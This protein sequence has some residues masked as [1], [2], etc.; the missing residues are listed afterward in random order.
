MP[1][2]RLAVVVAATA[3]V[4]AG[5]LGLSGVS[6]AATTASSPASSSATGGAASVQAGPGELALTVVLNPSDRATLRGLVERAPQLTD[7]QRQDALAAV[8]PSIATRARVAGVLR[9]AGFAITNTSSWQID[10][11]G[12]P[13]E[14][15]SFFGVDL[16][17][18][19]DDMHPAA[20]PV[21][22]SSIASSVTT[23]LGL[24]RRPVLSSRVLP[25]GG[26]SSA[27]LASAYGVA[28]T[29]GDGSG[30]TVATVQFSGWHRN[31][32]STYAS[33]A[34][35]AMPSV[36]EIPVGGASATSIDGN[37][38]VEVALDQEL[39]LAAAPKAAQRI[40]FATNDAQGMYSVWSQVAADVKP[41][42][43]TAVSTSWG[44]CESSTPSSVRSAVQDA[45]ARAVVAGG[46]VFAA[47]GDYGA[48]DCADSVHPERATPADVSFPASLPSVVGVGGTSLTKSGSGW[49]ETAWSDQS[50]YRGSG[51]GLSQT[52]PRP[53]YQNGI[54]ISGSTRAVPDISATADPTQG[55]TFYTQSAKS[56]TSSGFVL[57]G[58]TSAA[59]PIMAGQLAA[60]L[61]SFGCVSG[62]GD[63]HATLYGNPKDFRDV[64]SGNNLLYNAG[65]GYDLATG[66]GSPNWSALVN[67]LRPSCTR[68]ATRI[69]GSDRFTVAAMASQSFPTS[70]DTVFV[71]SGTNFPDAL[72]AGPA[73]AA[74]K[75]PLLLVTS[76]SVP[77]VTRAAIQRLAPERIVVV[78]GPVAVGDSVAAQLAG[79]GGATVT[80]IGGADRYAVS[81]AIAQQV[82]LDPTSPLYAGITPTG[83]YVASGRGYADA[84]SAGG[85]AA[86][87]G[88]PLLIVDGLAAG[89][90]DQTKALVTSMGGSTKVFGVGGPVVLAPQILN[91]LGG[92]SAVQY[93]G[94]DR[95]DTS[96]LVNAGAFTSAGTAYLSVGTN[97]PDAL[98]GSPLAAKSGAPLYITPGTCVAKSVRADL[99]T[100]GVTTVT[101]LGGTSALS[102]DVQGLRTCS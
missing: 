85:A 57:G 4:A 34:G 37:G 19:G 50:R 13:A 24:D 94:T 81:R 74:L 73:A 45:I 66:L 91:D 22:P 18:G 31:D 56:P 83:V 87:A 98:S 52:T 72:A 95:F 49:S 58:G 17:G 38:D 44:L 25:A 80:R 84:L 48:Y 93:A 7:D 30:T 102:M 35:I 23:V 26:K 16:V 89:A 96:H 32:L 15:E 40:Y 78:G 90:D 54:G 59:A 79:I 63:I 82:F 76:T 11:I 55:V 92:P 21:I 67:D 61:S 68:V 6:L 2:R 77:D 43:I 101:L 64:T 28:G 60:T 53:S 14:A 36:T 33:A 39:V 47:S 41:A 71:A 62:V 8:A 29:G 1:Y 27:D 9:A 46:T 3:S 70:T 97:F 100:L 88:D 99:D 10:L 69:S 20:A 75:A 12:T 86:K 42:G 65:S 5:A 51:G